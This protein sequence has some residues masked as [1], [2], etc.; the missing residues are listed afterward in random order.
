M[1]G[2]RR[3]FIPGGVYFF[4][5]TLDDRRSKILVDEI[6]ALRRA[7]RAA[8]RE[9]PFVM[10]A[11]VILPDHLHAILTLPPEDADFSTRWRR[12]K[13]LL[14]KGIPPGERLSA[15]RH[16]KAERGVW[17]RR[18]WEHAIRDEADYA[19]HVDYI[20]YNPVKHGY[21]QRV[22]AWPHSSFHRFVAE[23]VYPM[24]W[25]ADEMTRQIDKE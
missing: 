2:Y 1:V 20:H 4:T 9:R 6:G 19:A 25:A 18:F 24:D 10:D 16:M 17:Q 13:G 7:F 3:N 23:G 12:I 11:V 8:C 15:R 5:V 14:A 22:D 21:A